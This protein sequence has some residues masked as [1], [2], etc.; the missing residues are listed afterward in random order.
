MPKCSYC[1]KNYEFPRG[2]TLV[3]SLG[4]IKH[5][6]SSKCRKYSDMGRKKGKWA[7]EDKKV[8]EKVEEKKEEKVENSEKKD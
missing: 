7:L 4:K 6:C 3:D 5:L 8:K 1:G 2:L